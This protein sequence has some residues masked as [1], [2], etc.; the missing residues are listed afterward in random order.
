MTLFRVGD[1]QPN[2]FRHMDRYPIRPEKVTALRESMRTTTF[3][4]N[5]LARINSDG[6]PEI[7][8]GHHRR[9]A[10]RE[11]Y[12]ADHE[13]E[14]TIRDLDDDQMLKIM[15]RENMEEWGTSAIIEQETVRAVVE[16]YAEGRIHLS[17]LHLNTSEVRHAPSFSR[18]LLRAQQVPSSHL[19]T[20]KYT[21]Q[22]IA[23]F[24]GWVQPNGKAQDKVANALSALELI[25]EGILTDADFAGLTTKQAQAVVVQASKV[26]KERETRAKLAEQEVERA[27]EVAE[28]QRVA[29]ENAELQ[30]MAAE[31][32]AEQARL[33]YEQEAEQ[34]AQEEAQRQALLARQAKEREEAAA[35]QQEIAAKAAAHER[36]QANEAATAVGRHVSRDLRSGNRGIKQANE[37]AR[38]AGYKPPQQVPPHIDD[39]AR[40]LAGNLNKLLEPDTDKNAHVRDLELFIQYRDHAMAGSREELAQVL[41]NI[42]QRALGYAERIEKPVTLMQVNIVKELEENHG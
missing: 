3:W 38:E 32:R 14:L 6:K 37:S 35:L 5:M 2:Q 25:E 23:E 4:D 17:H 21:V 30:R 27:R 31:A 11:E 34:R 8:F 12:G 18:N 26:K 13:V 28:A 22:A 39:F 36:Q 16:A 41:R 1:I 40:K 10:L 19:A 33:R 9:Q 29:R 7:A 24:L 15:A 20:K 42:S